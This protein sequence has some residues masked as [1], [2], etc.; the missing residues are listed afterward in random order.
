MIA[1]RWWWVVG[2]GGSKGSSGGKNETKGLKN[3]GNMA[4]SGS[5]VKGKTCTTTIHQCNTSLAR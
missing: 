5:A 4:G 1:G 2:R 3:G